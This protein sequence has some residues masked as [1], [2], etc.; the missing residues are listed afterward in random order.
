MFFREVV[1]VAL[2]ILEGHFGGEFAL[3]VGYVAGKFFF[4]PGSSFAIGSFF[5]NV[6]SFFSGTYGSFLPLSLGSLMLDSI[7]DIFILSGWYIVLLMGK[8]GMGKLLM[9]NVA[10]WRFIIGER[11][12]AE[13]EIGMIVHPNRQL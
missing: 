9:R 3:A 10:N 5:L 6:L 13:E 1:F 8:K 12:E 4:E 7:Y 2:V 11:V